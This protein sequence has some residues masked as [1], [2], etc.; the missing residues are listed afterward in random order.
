[1]LR[2]FFALLITS[3]G[4]LVW[5]YPVAGNQGCATNC[6]GTALPQ[7]HEQI[8]VYAQAKTAPANP[9]I[10]SPEQVGALQPVE[11]AMVD[12]VHAAPSRVTPSSAEG[13][14]DGSTPGPRFFLIFGS[15]LIGARLIIAYRSR[16]LRKLAA[17]TH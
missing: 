14:D 5:G 11:S 8:E 6:E 9:A 12:D 16:K 7:V 4:S 1:M 3:A 15:V 10:F 2:I 17:E 13:T